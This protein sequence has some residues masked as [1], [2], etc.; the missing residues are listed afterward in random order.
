MTITRTQYLDTA[1]RD[2]SHDHHRAYYAQF[3]N[4]A[5]IRFVVDRIGGDKIL[6]STDRAFNDIPLALWDELVG[7]FR[8]RNNIVFGYNPMPV[9]IKFADVGD[10]PSTVGL[11]CVAKEAARQYR[12]AAHSSGGES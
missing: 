1:S 10:I 3:V 9:A 2:D 4:A 11:V 7:V 5:T 12:D 6:A 8:V